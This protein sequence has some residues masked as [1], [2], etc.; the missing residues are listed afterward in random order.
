MYDYDATSPGE[1]SLHEDDTLLVFD[2]EDDWLLVQNSKAEGK[3]GYVPGNYVEVVDYGQPHAPSRIV[4]PDSVRCSDRSNFLGVNPSLIQP[5][6]PVSTYID[7][8]D[9]VASAAKVTADDIKTWSLSEIDKKGK[10]KKGTLGIGNGAIFFA[11]EADKVRIC[12]NLRYEP[13]TCLMTRRLFKNGKRKMS[14]QYLLRNPSTYA[15]T[16]M[17]PPL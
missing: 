7:P 4:V 9:R 16:L 1:L 3:V 8:A 11:S 6:H 14:L 5:T 13:L 2:T 15:S 10:K 17:V 12:P